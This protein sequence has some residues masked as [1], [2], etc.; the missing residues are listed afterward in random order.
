MQTR[1][2]GVSATGLERPAE[3]GTAGQSGGGGGWGQREPGGDGGASWAV[4]WASAGGQ[5]VR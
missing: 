3:A 4:G 1:Q 2:E 5:A